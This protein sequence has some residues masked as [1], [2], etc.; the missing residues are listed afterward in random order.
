MAV[1]KDATLVEVS[2]G[3]HIFDDDHQ[4]ERLGLMLRGTARVYMTGPDGRILTV[5]HVRPGSMVT[6]V[7][8]GVG[9]AVPT[10]TEA[11]TDCSVIELQSTTVATL[12]R[13]DSSA[14]LAVSAE[15]ARRLDDVHREFA[16]YVFGSIAERLAHLLLESAV[17]TPRGLSAPVT[18]PQLAAAL[19]TA[20]EVVA[21]A[22]GRCASRASWQPAK[23]GSTCS[24]LAG[25]RP[26]QDR[27]S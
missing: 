2:R 15:Q 3:E 8:P 20:R 25:S 10:H 21:R 13:S 23:A 11:L 12:L 18:Q 7:V 9:Q 17:E 6:M 1:L 24:T 14:S 5:E 19:G 26:R 22:S 27:G 4:R 16:A